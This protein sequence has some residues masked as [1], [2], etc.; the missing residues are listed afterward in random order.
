M[1]AKEGIGLGL[2][3]L[4]SVAV[5]CSVAEF[6][7]RHF[8]PVAARHEKI[9]M[10]SSPTFQT[11]SQGA[12]RYVENQRIRSV[13]VAANHIVYDV[14][15][16]T[17]NLGFI[18]HEDYGVGPSVRRSDA[19]RYAFVGDSFTAG[20]HGGTPWVAAIRD[21]ARRTDP[22]LEIYNLG[23]EG[24]GFEQFSRLL[25]S[26]S[27]QLEFSEI[28][29]LALSD[30]FWRPMW[31][32]LVQGDELRFCGLE[33]SATECLQGPP[34]AR[35]VDEGLTQ[36]ELLAL[37][38]RLR[39][40]PPSG[41][42]PFRQFLVD[43]SRLGGLVYAQY[44]K[45]KLP[46]S[47]GLQESLSWLA[48]IRHAFPGKRIQLIHLPTIAEVAGADYELHPEE[49]VQALGIAYFPALKECTW[50]EK[51]FHADDGHPNAAGYEAIAR[52]VSDHLRLGD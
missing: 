15:Y 13:V 3:L 42:R 48:H 44:R 33:A 11:D 41:S 38:T 31:H 28:V 24:T 34:V 12:V 36:T 40:D 25:D 45:F 7:L 1:R 16:R 10:L 4:G 9:W 26:A 5:T 43:H 49:K 2:L 50:P 27:T 32:P 52:C 19:R 37:A 22:D 14:R 8:R 20:V 21:E 6:G 23:V 35:I 17:N 46:R 30:D 18:D 51:M 29:I 39:A 47:K